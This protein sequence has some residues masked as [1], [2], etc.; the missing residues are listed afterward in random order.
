[1]HAYLADDEEA[2]CET[3]QHKAQ[4]DKV[5]FL[6]AVARPRRFRQRRGSEQVS[7]GSTNAGGLF[8]LSDST[9]ST[10]VNGDNCSGFCENHYN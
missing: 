5:M 4:I 1:M 10:N 3:V 7:H 9:E 8:C 6:A 2:I